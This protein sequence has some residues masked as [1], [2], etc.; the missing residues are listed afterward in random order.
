MV[1]LDGTL[2]VLE[3]LALAHARPLVEAASESRDTYGFA[4]VP[5]GPHEMEAYVRRALEAPGEMPFA[6][7]SHGRVVVLDRPG[8]VAR[9]GGA[10]GI[11]IWIRVGTRA[12]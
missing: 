7:V 3:P 9:G 8:R 11:L 10:A 1:R 2:V 12:V 5:D 6:I 4:E